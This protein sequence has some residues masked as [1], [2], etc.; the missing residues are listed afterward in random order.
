MSFPM[1]FLYTESVHGEG[2]EVFMKG[3]MDFSAAGK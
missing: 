2:M 1:M 3:L